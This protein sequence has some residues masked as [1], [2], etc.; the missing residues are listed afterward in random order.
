[1]GHASR[2]TE[3]SKVNG[4]WN[5]GGLAQG[6]SGEK[7]FSMLPRNCFC[8]IFVKNVVAFCPCP[9]SLPEARAN[10]ISKQP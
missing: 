8:D 10:E 2:N 4:D 6:V 9:K 5:C 1:M 3:D 7:N